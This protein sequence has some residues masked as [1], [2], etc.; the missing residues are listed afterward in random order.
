[1]TLTF[2]NCKGNIK[3]PHEPEINWNVSSFREA[4]DISLRY[5]NK[6]MY[7]NWKHSNACII[8]NGKVIYKRSKGINKEGNNG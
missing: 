8:E 3:Q 6:K 2:H 5:K 4:K 1:M 7:I